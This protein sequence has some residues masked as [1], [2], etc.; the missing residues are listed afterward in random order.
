MFLREAFVESTQLFANQEIVVPIPFYYNLPLK[1]LSSL[2]ALVNVTDCNEWYMYSFNKES[3][4][5]LDIE[6]F[7]EN[8]GRHMTKPRGSGML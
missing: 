3:A 5:D 7:G 8:Q 1:A 6:Y 4:T 2:K